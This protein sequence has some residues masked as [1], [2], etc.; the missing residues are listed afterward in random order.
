MTDK[1]LTRDSDDMLGGEVA[2]G[3]GS[4]CETCGWSADVI[5]VEEYEPGRWSVVE[6]FGC[7]G[8]S[9]VYGLTADEATA[10]VRA[11]AVF[12]PEY[13]QYRDALAAELEALAAEG[14]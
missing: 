11:L 4:D 9:A 7:T 8:G 13:T 1:I 12:R 2:S 5:E 6:R 14:A 3:P 10:R